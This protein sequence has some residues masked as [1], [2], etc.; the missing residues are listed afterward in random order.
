MYINT[1]HSVM[2]LPLETLKKTINQG[3]VFSSDEHS[4]L[5][6]RTLNSK[7]VGEKIQK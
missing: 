5:P 6:S 3:I 7:Y 2:I 4:Y 1:L